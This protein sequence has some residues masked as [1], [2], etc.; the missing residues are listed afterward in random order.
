MSVL[1]V[2]TLLGGGTLPD[3]GVSQTRLHTQ[4]DLQPSALLLLTPSRGLPTVG[5]VS[6]ESPSQAR[7]VPSAMAIPL[8]GT[9]L[10]WSSDTVAVWYR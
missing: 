7:T 4:K 3:G 8:Y 9:A 10:A 5:R 1:L 2:L 6:Q